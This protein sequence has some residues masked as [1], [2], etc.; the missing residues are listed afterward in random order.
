MDNVRLIADKK[1]SFSLLRPKDMIDILGCSMAELYRKQNDDDFPPKFKISER[2]VGWKQQ[3]V[4]EYIN[5]HKVE[6]V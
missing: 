5:A 2:I 1:Y 3:D 6:A 4:L